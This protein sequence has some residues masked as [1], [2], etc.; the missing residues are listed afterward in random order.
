[1]QD[2]EQTNRVSGRSFKSEDEGAESALTVDHI[3]NECADRVL[4]RAGDSEFS[5][6]L[7]EDLEGD[8][9]CEYRRAGRG[10]LPLALSA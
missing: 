1:M 7:H 8:V 9:V 6:V 4:K 10:A 3:E 2:S 5:Q